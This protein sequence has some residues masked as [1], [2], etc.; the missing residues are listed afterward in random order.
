MRGPRWVGCGWCWGRA[1][2]EAL[3]T[4]SCLR[5]RV[6]RLT[7]V[8]SPLIVTLLRSCSAVALWISAARWCRVCSGCPA[9]WARVLLFGAEGVEFR[10]L[11]GRFVAPLSRPFSR[12]EVG[13]L[14]KGGAAIEAHFPGLK[15]GPLLRSVFHFQNLSAASFGV[16]PSI[17]RRR[18]ACVPGVGFA[19]VAGLCDSVRGLLTSPSVWAGVCRESATEGPETY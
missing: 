8:V 13:A 16:S 18:A 6:I 15:R 2:F 1:G 9:W 3:F 7:F 10:G 12:R 17:F 4:S 19:A 5:V 14:G 11:R